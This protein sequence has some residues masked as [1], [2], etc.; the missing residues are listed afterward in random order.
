VE[1][2]FYTDYSLRLL[3]YLGLKRERLCVI[4]EV[5]ETYGISRNHLVK[6]VHRLGQ[7]GFIHTYRGRTGGISLAHDPAEINLGAVVRYTEGAPKLV[8]CF[9]GP[10]NNCRITQACRLA[11]I[12]EEAYDNF[13]A[14]LDR[15]TLAD[16]LTNPAK[17]R[18]V[19]AL[20][21]AAA[22]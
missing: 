21:S 11:G 15:Y 9:R 17:L 20:R 14:T 5:A 6:I 12:L 18:R 1:L 4:S 10:A 2:T 16:L 19:L 3:I 13:M 8:E 22:A 7:G